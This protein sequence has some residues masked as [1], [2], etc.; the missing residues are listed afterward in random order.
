LLGEWEDAR[1][2]FRSIDAF[3]EDGVY[4]EQQTSLVSGTAIRRRFESYLSLASRFGTRASST[5]GVNMAVDDYDW[6]LL[7]DGSAPPSEPGRGNLS[8]RFAAAWRVAS[9][10]TCR[11]ALSL[12]RQPTFLNYL[13]A[14][15]TAITLGRP[16]DTR[17]AIAGVEVR[18]HGFEARIDAY[19]RDDRG[20][21]FPVQDLA[22]K[23]SASLDEGTAWGLEV[24]VRSPSWRRF[25][26]WA[27][28]ARS[29]A[30]WSTPDGDVPRSF[31][32]PH[33]ATL[34]MNHRWLGALNLN[35][36]ARYHSGNAYTEARPVGGPY[37]WT[38]AFGPFMGARYPDYF[39]LD[40]R[41]SYPLHLGR[42]GVMY[43]DLVNA[44]DRENVY[45]YW[46]AFDELPNGEISPRR[47]FMELFPR[48]PYLG[49]EVTF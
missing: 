24:L 48:F 46:W 34:S 30:V 33:A 49:F 19:H 18:H 26:V 1:V 6:D 45:Y 38:P 42:G 16:R 29:R 41:A 4:V 9:W 44:T 25:D 3:I 5:V 14:D 2:Q 47:G 17:E 7:R 37:T 20:V 39:R 8:P 13:D 10:L 43:V 28:Y 36:T 35:A 12:L 40:F 32:Q 21:S 31:D 22:G 11:A 15:R 23:P 27:S